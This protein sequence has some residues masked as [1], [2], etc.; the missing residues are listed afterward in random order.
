MHQL[1]VNSAFLQGSLKEEVYMTQPPGLRDIQYPNHV[2][3]FHK[4]IYGLRQSPRAWH[5]ALKAFITSHGFT[6][7]KSDLSLFIYASGPII[8]YF[9]VYV[10]D[11]LLTVMKP[12][13]YT[14]L[15]TPFPI[16]FLL[17]TWERHTASLVLNS[18]QQTR[19]CCCLNI[20]STEKSLRSLTWL[21]PN[22][23][24]H[25]CPLQPHSL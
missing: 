13:S 14:T 23:H 22:R 25:L 17:R 5:D 2:C 4:S 21:A 3:K 10:D 15:F 16:D 12:N 20:D 24:P 11:L 19:V 1:D 6:T 8:T 7:S 18:S 9:L